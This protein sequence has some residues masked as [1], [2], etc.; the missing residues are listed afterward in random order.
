MFYIAFKCKLWPDVMKLNTYSYISDGNKFIIQ[1][2]PTSAVANI[3]R[4]RDI[5]LE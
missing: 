3:W 5:S 1:I 4:P 2:Y